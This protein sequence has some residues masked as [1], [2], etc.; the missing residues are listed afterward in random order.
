MKL[1]WPGHFDVPKSVT[2]P[3]AEI[4]SSLSASQCNSSLGQTQSV[5]KKNINFNKPSSSVNMTTDQQQ[6][7]LP[8]REGRATS[9]S[10]P[11]TGDII[12]VN[13]RYTALIAMCL[14]FLFIWSTV[15]SSVFLKNTIDEKTYMNEPV[16]IFHNQERI[17]RVMF[18]VG[19]EMRKF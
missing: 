7:V 9:T 3:S 4:H 11:A 16:E 12:E 1:F 18:Q 8:S 19:Q 10:T 14:G 15:V 17:G 2:P 6:F 13:F 5:S